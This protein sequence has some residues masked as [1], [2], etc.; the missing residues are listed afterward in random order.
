MLNNNIEKLND[1]PVFNQT[2][3][4][5]NFDINSLDVIRFGVCIKYYKIFPKISFLDF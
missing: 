2:Y 5:E 3:H 1:F 4:L